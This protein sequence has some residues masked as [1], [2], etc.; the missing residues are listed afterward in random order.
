MKRTSNKGPANEK[1]EEKKKRIEK[2]SRS[3]N[4]GVATL[5]SLIKERKQPRIVFFFKHCD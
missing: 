2:R 3:T 4:D 5:S 1:K